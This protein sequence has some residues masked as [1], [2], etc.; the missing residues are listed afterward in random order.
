MEGKLKI[1]NILFV[2]IDIFTQKWQWDW[3]VSPQ[4]NL[5]QEYLFWAQPSHF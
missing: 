4:H 3:L 2:A 5:S 1:E